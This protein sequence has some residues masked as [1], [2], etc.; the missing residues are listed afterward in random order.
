MPES[1]SGRLHCTC[2][3]AEKSLVGSNPT[4]G[5]K[6]LVCITEVPMFYTH[7]EVVRFYHKEQNAGI[8]TV[9]F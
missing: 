4:L 9:I 3:A 6:F 5:S 8:A 1:Y 7:K 2:N